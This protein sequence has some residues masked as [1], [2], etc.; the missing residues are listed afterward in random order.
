MSA[1][2]A[3]VMQEWFRTESG[4]HRNGGDWEEVGTWLGVVWER[5]GKG[6]GGKVLNG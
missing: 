1:N 3:N 2:R 5:D 4:W 6:V